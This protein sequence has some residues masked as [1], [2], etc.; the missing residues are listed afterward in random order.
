MYSS[1][2]QKDKIIHSN[3]RKMS[4]LGGIKTMFAGSAVKSQI[5]HCQHFKTA[6]KKA[7]MRVAIT[8]RTLSWATKFPRLCQSH[9]WAMT[10]TQR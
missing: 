3:F 4:P 1:I 6:S 9:A 7:R 2:L 10:T 5:K 8:L